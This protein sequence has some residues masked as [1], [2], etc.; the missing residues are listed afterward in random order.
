M[1]EETGGNERMRNMNSFVYINKYKIFFS[2]LCISIPPVNILPILRLGILGKLRK[3]L[4]QT[5]AEP[6]KNQMNGNPYLPS[7]KYI[8][9][10]EYGYNLDP[11]SREY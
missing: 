1:K 5:I 4:F 2:I 6:F 9:I 7:R 8:F 10:R 11:N 3:G